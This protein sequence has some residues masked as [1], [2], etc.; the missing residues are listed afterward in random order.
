MKTNLEN[1][2]LDDSRFD[3]L[4]DGELN[5][6]ERRDL[7]AGLDDEPS[8]WRRCALAFLE[9][10]CWKQALGVLTQE[11]VRAVPPPVG[12]PRRSFRLGRTGT[13][14]AMAASFLVAMW[15]G[16]WVQQ[17]RVGQHP[18]PIGAGVG[19]QIATNLPQSKASSSPW[20]IVNVSSGEQGPGA[21]IDLP[22]V[23]RNNI[24]KQWLRSLPAAIPEDVMQA[25]NRTGHQVRQHRELV[26]VPLEDGRRLVVPVDQV[27]VHYVG[28]KTY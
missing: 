12:L 14:L 16:S 8:G 22:A 25:L 11:G 13:L 27:D 23:E 1:T 18:S 19:S 26:P 6:Q 2:S 21:S 5:E 9:A 15:L 3:R 20:K 28:N 4:V 10:Q 24:D 17:A 7:L